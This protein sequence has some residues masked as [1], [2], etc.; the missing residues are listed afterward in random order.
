MRTIATTAATFRTR[1]TKHFSSA[2]GVPVTPVI[3]VAL[4]QETGVSSSGLTLPFLF[5]R[6]S[7][8]PRSDTTGQVSVASGVAVRATA[9]AAAGDSIQF[10][11][12]SYS[13]G[14]AKAAG[15]SC[16]ILAS[17]NQPAV[18]M[19][20]IAP[21]ALESGFWALWSS[22][23]FSGTLTLLSEGTAQ[24]SSDPPR[25]EI[26]RTLPDGTIQTVGLLLNTTVNNTGHLAAAATSI[27]QSPQ[28]LAPNPLTGTF[29]ATRPPPG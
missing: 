12:T 21:F 9:I 14:R 22:G 3:P 20:G 4:D 7:M 28:L 27:G 24:S 17:G 8:M 11:G 29:D 10:G 26:Q 2:C 6:G 16:A 15:R 18:T 23:S 25:V 13:A 1:Q 19:P 5:G